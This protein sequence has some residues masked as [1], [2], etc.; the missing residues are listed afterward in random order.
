LKTPEIAGEVKVA[1]LTDLEIKVT[2]SVKTLIVTDVQR[3]FFNPAGSL[4]V[5]GGELL[6]AKIAETAK[7]F[8]HI[9]FTLDFHPANHCSFKKQGGIWPAHCVQYTEGS[10]LAAEFQD[11]L[12]EGY[13]KVRYFFKGTDPNAE[14]YAAFEYLNSDNDPDGFIKLFNESDE[15]AICGIAGDY[16]VLE[17]AKQLLRLGLA[18]K[19]VVLTDLTVSISGDGII[20]DFIKE[21]NLK[22]R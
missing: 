18:S 6:P 14:Q 8:D 13:P 16:C 20:K 12:S 17:T 3:D 11:I 5:P 4:Y 9:V 15:I 10:G 19:L 22:T 7:Y 2:M 1:G 21:N